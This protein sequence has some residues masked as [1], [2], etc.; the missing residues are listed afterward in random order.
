MSA[1]AIVLLAGAAVAAAGPI[2]FVGRAVPHVARA[3]TGPDYRWVLPYSAVRAPILL[4]GGPG[5][6]PR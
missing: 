4:L 1:L 6:T 5:R 3:I 2:A